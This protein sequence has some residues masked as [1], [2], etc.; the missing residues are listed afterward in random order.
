MFNLKRRMHDSTSGP[1]TFVA[2]S[3]SIVGTIAGQGAFVCCGTIEGDCDIDGSLTLALG[4]RWKGT[5]KA[6]DIIV[7]GTVEGNV[8]ARQ[9]IEIG[10]SARVT[11]NLSAKSIAVAEGAIIEGE[12]KVRSG[13]APVKFHEKRQT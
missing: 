10:G 3:T 7:G 1:P 8:V 2:P 9:R 12:L 6:T 4:G 11:G 13:E 5:M